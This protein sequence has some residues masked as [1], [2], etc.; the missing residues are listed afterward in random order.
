MDAGWVS[1]FADGRKTA[2]P[3]Q[4]PKAVL[5]VPALDAAS[6]VFLF[7]ALGPVPDVGQLPGQDSSGF[8]GMTLTLV[9]VAIVTIS[10][11]ERGAAAESTA[12]QDA[13]TLPAQEIRTP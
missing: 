13:S 10:T 2:P 7:P 11:F 3:S 1:N 6:G 12:C 8:F 5:H 9:D 4:S